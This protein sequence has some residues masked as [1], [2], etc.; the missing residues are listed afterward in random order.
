METYSIKNMVNNTV[1]PVWGQM[2]PN[3]ITMIISYCMQMS[4]HYVVHL[5]LTQYCMS[6]IIQFKKVKEKRNRMNGPETREG[7]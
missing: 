7:R 1:I 6:T 4:N 5:K 3:L 2:V